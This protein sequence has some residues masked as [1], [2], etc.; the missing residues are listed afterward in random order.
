MMN[1]PI[2]ELT[3][4]LIVAALLGGA[5]GFEREVA[6]KAA[7]FRTHVLVALG[8]ALFGILSLEGFNAADTSRIAAQVVSG[9]GFL[10]AGAIFR[11]GATVQGL[12]TAAALWAA[13][14]IGLAA[15]A[16]EIPLAATA[17]LVA[18]L[19][20]V[21]LR[22]VNT[23]MYQRLGFVSTRVT[24][25][26]SDTSQFLDIWNLANQIDPAIDDVV[27][28]GSVEGGGTIVLEADPSKADT[29]VEL[30]NAYQSV[31][32]AEKEDQ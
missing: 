6:R 27:F 25:T 1:S 13:A 26:I 9:V 4:R 17:T 5:I 29:L 20:L 19:V 11:E 7:G 8:A 10:G 14:A 32:Q 24:V 22:V 12:T 31:Q 3:L 21:A 28:R 15:G 18:I 30:F 16:G 2:L 23:W